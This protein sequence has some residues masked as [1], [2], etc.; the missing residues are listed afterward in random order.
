MTLGMTK[1]ETFL[2]IGQA[3]NVELTSI[4]EAGELP[5]Q[6][7]IH[8]MQNGW[9]HSES[10]PNFR[11]DAVGLER[12]RSRHT[13]HSISWLCFNASSFF[14]FFSQ[15]IICSSLSWGLKG[16]KQFFPQN[17]HISPWIWGHASPR[18]QSPTAANEQIGRSAGSRLLKSPRSSD[19]DKYWCWD[20]WLQAGFTGGKKGILEGERS[21][22]TPGTIVNPPDAVAESETK[23]W[24]ELVDE[25]ATDDC[26]VDTLTCSYLHRLPY[27]QAP[28]W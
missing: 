11:S 21:E 16:C 26:R 10:N 23:N 2:H 6:F 1:Y 4:P 5:R 8:D 20:F 13:L 27:E 28:F 15:V 17:G 14:C 12:T 22:V 3:L 7:L 24:W 9:S 18:G 19:S 25:D